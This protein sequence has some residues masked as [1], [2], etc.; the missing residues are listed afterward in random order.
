MGRALQP[1][2]HHPL[3][4]PIKHHGPPVSPRADLFPQSR[5]PARR[6]TACAV[7]ISSEPRRDDPLCGS[8]PL[9]HSRGLPQHDFLCHATLSCAPVVC[10]TSRGRSGRP[11][12]CCRRRTPASPLGQAAP[13]QA[14]CRACHPTL[15]RPLLSL[16]HA[17]H[18]T[19]PL[20][21]I[22]GVLCQ[23]VDKRCQ[24]KIPRPAP[25]PLC[26]RPTLTLLSCLPMPFLS[27]LP[28]RVA[29]CRAH[30]SHAKPFKPRSPIFVRT[31]LA[32]LRIIP[33]SLPHLPIVGTVAADL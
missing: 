7:R 32:P 29:R 11:I 12:G 14:T 6:S 10:P 28:R 2:L 13:G 27:H 8:R 15:S 4:Q 22:T 16:A 5:A 31:R 23:S 17:C 20:A 3:P 1:D 9:P 21:T 25:A 33:T 24:D 18:D 30:R 26:R 19:N